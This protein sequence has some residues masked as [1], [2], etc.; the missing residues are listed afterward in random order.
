MLGNYYEPVGFSSLDTGLWFHRDEPWRD[1]RLLVSC[2]DIGT[3]GRAFMRRQLYAADGRLIVSMIQEALIP[4]TADE[5]PET[6]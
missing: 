2:C 3:A 5:T 1:W 4:G 6:P